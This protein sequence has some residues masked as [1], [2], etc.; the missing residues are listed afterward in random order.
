ML[1]GLCFAA[2]VSVSTMRDWNVWELGPS[3][4]VVGP[5]QVIKVILWCSGFCLSLWWDSLWQGWGSLQEQ[6][7]TPGWLC[8][9]AF[10]P[11]SCWFL[12]GL[13]A[14]LSL[15]HVVLGSSGSG[16]LL[17]ATVIC[18]WVCLPL[19]VK[20]CWMANVMYS[21]NAF[22]HSLHSLHHCHNKGWSVCKLQDLN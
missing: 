6:I 21:L 17:D 13:G 1:W 5:L 10:S 22:A 19:E 7:R 15:G 11:F 14:Q 16:E 3:C 18:V 8:W 2:M 9:I 12:L 4:C 20:G